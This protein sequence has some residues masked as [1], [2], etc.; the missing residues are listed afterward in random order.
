MDLKVDGCE[1]TRVSFDYAVTLLVDPNTKIRLATNVVLTGAD[2]TSVPFRSGGADMPTADLVG[3]LHQDIA[4]AWVSDD[5]VL[6]I[7]FADD[8]TLRATPDPDY[9]AWEIAGENG[10]RVICMPGGK[11]AIWDPR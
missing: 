2:G 4:Q 8:A 1:L 5:G 9:E 3:L 11:L 6:T 7:R 10:F